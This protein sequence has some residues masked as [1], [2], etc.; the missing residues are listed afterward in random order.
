MKYLIYIVLL[1]LFL[2]FNFSIDLITLVL[3][4][5]IF[6][7]DER[8]ALIFSFLIGLLIDLYSP[9]HFGINILVYLVLT[10]LLLY[11]KKYIAQ[12]FAT[13]FGTFTIFYL[14]KIA[15]VHII[16]SSPLTIQPIIITII[17]FVPFFLV[18]NKLVN[19]V[20]MKT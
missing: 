4:F 17:A 10:Q 16:L 9:V 13:I 20:W 14:T 2:P 1:Y 15:I 19:G 8:F 18:L 6:N 11:I 5:I 3:F 12:N 7:E